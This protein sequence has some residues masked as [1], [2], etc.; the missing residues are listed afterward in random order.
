LAEIRVAVITIS[1]RSYHNERP[2][3]SGPA[4]ID[5]VSSMGWK[6]NYSTIV[7]DDLSMIVSI[8]RE[9]AS[10][11]NVDMI[12]TTGGTGLSPRDNTPEATMQVVEKIVPGLT[13][14]MRMGSVSQ[15]PNSILSRAVAG[16]TQGKLIINLPGS[17][18]GAIE[19]LKTIAR[20]I[21]HAI[22]ILK[23]QEMHES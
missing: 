19:T 18:K 8:L 15:N 12:L 10:R 17:P 6:V 4:L 5:F 2:D 14:F 20:V 21:P 7:N 13:E 11:K 22:G 23:E 16:I 1:D 9:Y 3:L